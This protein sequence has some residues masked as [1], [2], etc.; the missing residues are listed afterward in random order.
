MRCQP[1]SRNPGDPGLDEPSCVDVIIFADI[2]PRTV[3]STAHAHQMRCMPE[4]HPHAPPGGKM[5]ILDMYAPPTRL[6]FYIRV[7]YNFALSFDML[8]VAMDL[9][10]T[11][12]A[13][14]V[15]ISAIWLLLLYK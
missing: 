11:A 14:G 10:I 6:S 12:A 9:G 3:F 15:G 2:K 5:L 1:R 4:P 13:I 8:F 7:V